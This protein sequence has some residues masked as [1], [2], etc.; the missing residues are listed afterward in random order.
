[1]TDE[2]PKRVRGL[3]EREAAYRQG[4]LDGLVHAETEKTKKRL[5]EDERDLA[6]AEGLKRLRARTFVVK[7]GR[8]PKA[9]GA[10]TQIDD[11]IAQ[12]EI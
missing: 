1:M 6:V 11:L 4:F 12:R 3:K 7:R 2:K 10:D 5:I 9:N 8:R